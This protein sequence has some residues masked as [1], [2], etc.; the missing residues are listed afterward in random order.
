MHIGIVKWLYQ[1]KKE[2]TAFCHTARPEGLLH[3]HEAGLKQTEW[4]KKIKLFKKWKT[5]CRNESDL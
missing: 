4:F 5:S 1:N 2:S 3:D